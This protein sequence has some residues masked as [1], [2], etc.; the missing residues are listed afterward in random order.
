MTPVRVYLLVY[1]ALAAAAGWMLQKAGI[2][3]HVPRSWLAL[4]VIVVVVPGVMLG[5]AS[6]RSRP[7][8]PS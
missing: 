5:L 4:A 7:H 2:L 6:V 1:F 8:K 3:A